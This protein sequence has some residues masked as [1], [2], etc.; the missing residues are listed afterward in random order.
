MSEL[1]ILENLLPPA[2]D[3]A[4]L[5]SSLK[6][7]EQGDLLEGIPLTWIAPSGSDVITGLSS[8]EKEEFPYVAQE[9]TPTHVIITT[10]TCDLL[11][12]GPGTKRAFVQVSPVYPAALYGQGQQASG[13][14]RQIVYLFPLR[15]G[16]TPHFADLRLSVPMAKSIL[17]GRQP[18]RS[19]FDVEDAWQFAETVAHLYR[20]PALPDAVSEVLKSAVSRFIEAQGKSSPEIREIEQVRV[21]IGKKSFRSTSIPIELLVFGR[22]SAPD[23]SMKGP[24]LSQLN[25]FGGAVKPDYNLT[26]LRFT[27]PDDCSAKNY[28]NSFPLHLPSLGPLVG[29]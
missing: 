5:R 18:I 13:Q 26:G 22:T 23:A 9:L 17:I 20:R 1:V 28:R 12:K 2:E 4:K 10:Q 16:G 24:W 7:W 29:F 3:W 6:N 25:D 8:V 11:G 27:S 21:L 19:G 14:N 15:V